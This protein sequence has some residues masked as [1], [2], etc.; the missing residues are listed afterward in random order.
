[1]SNKQRVLFVPRPKVVPASW[2]SV[3]VFRVCG[4]LRTQH[5]HHLCCVL[6]VSRKPKTQKRESFDSGIIGGGA[7]R[8]SLDSVYHMQQWM[9]LCRMDD[10]LA[11]QGLSGGCYAI[12][13]GRRGGRGGYL[14]I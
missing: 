13:G 5:A 2:K 8:T 9:P 10:G 11:V 3:G 14:N 4:P 12:L 1:M 6:L 7:L